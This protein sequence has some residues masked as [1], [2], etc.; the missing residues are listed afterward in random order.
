[1]AK[2]T[3]IGAGSVE[4]TRNILADLCSFSELH[5]SFSIS[6][7]DI[8]AERLA[9]AERAAR[10]VVDTTGARYEIA[11]HPGRRSGVDRPASLNNGIPVRR[12]TPPSTTTRGAQ[13]FWT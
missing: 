13:R 11:A 2:V 6:L 4:F 10:Q 3:I 12:R 8:D 1:M 9:Y 7:H 5:G